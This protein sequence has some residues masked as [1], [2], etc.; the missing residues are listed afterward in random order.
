MN[1]V[2]DHYLKLVEWSAEDECYIGR[3]PGL[4]LGGV[5]GDDELEVYKE[6]C[7]VVEEWIT[8]A[9]ENGTKLP[10]P[11]A[12][13]TYSGKF[14]LRI[15]PALHEELD[16][17]ATEA[18]D[19]L[20]RYC[21]KHLQGSMERKTGLQALKREMDLDSVAVVAEQ[22]AATKKKATKKKATKKKRR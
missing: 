3:C 2:S 15:D 16:I 5:H 20:N 11:T 8:E 4:M 21:A 14:V 17:R 9:E 22:A 19:S 7:Q 6:L 18:G 10:A 12:N 1:K 13:K